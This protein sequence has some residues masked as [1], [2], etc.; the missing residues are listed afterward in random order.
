MEGVGTDSKGEEMLCGLLIPHTL[1]QL[2]ARR[3]PQVLGE[4][5]LHASILVR[6]A[7][8]CLCLLGP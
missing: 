2:E 7:G 6:K 5:V 8:E 1:Q 3:E 4:H